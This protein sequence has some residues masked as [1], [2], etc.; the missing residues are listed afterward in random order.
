MNKMKKLVQ[1]FTMALKEK[2]CPTAIICFRL[3]N[4]D[5]PGN[6]LLSGNI[7]GNNTDLAFLYLQIGNLL[8][9]LMS[10]SVEEGKQEN[11]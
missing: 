8:T 6:Y 4:P 10:K 7:F 3:P 2:G 9:N 11:K 1:K 5:E